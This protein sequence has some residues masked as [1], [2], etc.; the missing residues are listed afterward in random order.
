M[1]WRQTTREARKDRDSQTTRRSDGME[2]ADFVVGYVMYC[3]DETRF[4][5]KM[6]EADEIEGYPHYYQRT[7][8]EALLEDEQIE[9][10][11][12]LPAKESPLVVNQCDNDAS[13]KNNQTKKSDSSDSW[14]KKRVKCFIYHRKAQAIRTAYPVWSGDW[15]FVGLQRQRN[16]PSSHFGTNKLGSIGT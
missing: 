10:E 14:D 16:L 9:T 6:E 3:D 8:V 11:S 1:V 15:A 4:R 12:M 13:V 2:H 7:V 5:A